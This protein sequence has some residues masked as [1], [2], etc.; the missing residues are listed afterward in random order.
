MQANAIHGPP[1]DKKTDLALPN[2]VCNLRHQPSVCGMGRLSL[3]VTASGDRNLA[4]YRM[5][6]HIDTD[7]LPT[8]S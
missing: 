4:R 8:I 1:P 7:Q 5:G 6:K 3:I 2:T